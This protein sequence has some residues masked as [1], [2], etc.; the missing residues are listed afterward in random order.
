MT[1]D[2]TPFYACAFC[3]L[4]KARFP[5]RV[6]GCQGLQ[7][8][9]LPA[10]L[11]SRAA[12]ADY[13]Q[14]VNKPLDPGTGQE[15]R[16]RKVIRRGEEPQSHLQRAKEHTEIVQL[17]RGAS[18]VSAGSAPMPPSSDGPTLFSFLPRESLSWDQQATQV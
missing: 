4:T 10:S 14:D 18:A 15:A 5:P 13:K 16:Q 17:S 12:C 11:H 7:G 9:L 8:K 2:H 6:R 3:H 1:C